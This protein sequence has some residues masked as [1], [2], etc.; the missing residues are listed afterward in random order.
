VKNVENIEKRRANNKMSRKN[1][2]TIQIPTDSDIDETYTVTCPHCNEEIDA[3]TYF[4]ISAIDITLDRQRRTKYFKRCPHCDRKMHITVSLQFT[5]SDPGIQ[6]ELRSN[7]LDLAVYNGPYIDIYR[8]TVPYLK[9][10][11]NQYIKLKNKYLKESEEQKCQ[12]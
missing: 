10:A 11:I 12:K 2:K 9:K 8:S 6:H 7:L 3:E 4:Y 1:Q 5:A